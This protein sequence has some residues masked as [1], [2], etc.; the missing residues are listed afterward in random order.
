M[1]YWLI[2]PTVNRVTLEAV[3]RAKNVRGRDNPDKAEAIGSPVENADGSMMFTGTT[4]M[5][6][7]KA[8]ALPAAHAPWLTVTNDPSFMKTWKYPADL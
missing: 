6:V 2:F 4:R 8:A 5:G 7:T 3:Y 1:T